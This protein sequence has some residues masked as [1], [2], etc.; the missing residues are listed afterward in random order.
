MVVSDG[1]FFSVNFPDQFYIP[2]VGGGYFDVPDRSAIVRPPAEETAVFQRT[3]PVKLVVDLLD[4]Q[5]AEI[6]LAAETRIFSK[7][8]FSEAVSERPVNYPHLRRVYWRSIGRKNTGFD[9]AD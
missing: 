3:D 2:F 6:H 1:Q 4:A 9:I 8:L 5:F 7:S